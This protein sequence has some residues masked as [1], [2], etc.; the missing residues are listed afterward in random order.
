MLIA[1]A[2]SALTQAGRQ[3]GVV[4]FSVLCYGYGSRHDVYDA[5]K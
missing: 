3:L 5:V 4:W 1:T 2:A